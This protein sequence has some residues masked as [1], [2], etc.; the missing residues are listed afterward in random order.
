MEDKFDQ[1]YATGKEWEAKHMY[2][3]KYINVDICTKNYIHDAITKLLYL[4]RE[5]SINYFSLRMGYF[6]FINK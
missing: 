6:Y 3:T 2:S 4:K 1:R 5:Q